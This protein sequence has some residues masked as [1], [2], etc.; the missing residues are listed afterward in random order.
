MGAGDVVR[1]V[2]L[3]GFLD[4]LPLDPR[5]PYL[6]APEQLAAQHAG[7]DGFYDACSGWGALAWASV[8]LQNYAHLTDRLKQLFYR[9]DYLQKAAA[10]T[11]M[12]ET[13]QERGSMI[14]FDNVTI[15]TPLGQLL[16]KDLTFRVDEGQSLLICGH[17]G[18]GKSSIIRCLCSLWPVVEGHI[19]R[20]GGAV[21]AE[22]DA[23]LHKQLYYLPQKPCNVLGSLSD[24]LTYPVKLAGGLPE[25][26]LRRWLRYVDLEYI[27]DRNIA[28]NSVSRV[29]RAEASDAQASR[30]IDWE[31]LL[32]LGEQ[33]ALSIARML[34]HHPRFAILDECTSGVGKVLEQRLFEI[35]QEVGISCI[36]IAHRPALKEFHAS[37]L[38]LTG[39]LEH[40][41][42]GWELSDI[43]HSRKLTPIR[44]PCVDT[45]EVHRR[46]ESFLEVDRRRRPSVHNVDSST[47]TDKTW[48][49]Q[50]SE[51][52][53]M[54]Q[55]SLVYKERAEQ[56]KAGASAADIVRKRWPSTAMRLWAIIRLGLCTRSE[57]QLA[58]KRVA[59]MVLGLCAQAK[60]YWWYNTCQVGMMRASM[61]GDLPLVFSAFLS[62]LV[63]GVSCGIA[64]QCVKFQAARLTKGIWESAMNRLQNRIMSGG[65]LSVVMRPSDKALATIENPAVRLSELLGVFESIS[66]QVKSVVPVVSALYSLP[67]L[68]R[69]VGALGPAFLA[70]LCVL[71]H[72]ARLLVPDWAAIKARSALLESRFQVLH[73]R[74]RSIAEPVAF[75]GGGA[76]ERR[77][78]EPHFDA[79]LNH[80]ERVSRRQT[81]HDIT[82]SIF[83]DHRNIPISL[84]AFVAATFAS[85]NRVATSIVGTSADTLLS[86][87]LFDRGVVQPALSGVVSL[88]D[89]SDAIGDIDGQCLR[90]LELVVTLESV[91]DP[92]SG[93]PVPGDGKISIS[94]LDLVTQRGSCLAQRLAFEVEVG[95]PIVVT[96]PN[97]SGKSLL[98]SVLL[99]LWPVAGVDARV[100]IAGASGPRPPLQIM[101]A[102]P[103]R[104]Y[105]SSGSLAAQLA[106]P[107]VLRLPSETPFGLLVSGFSNGTTCEMLQKHFEALG[108]LSRCEMLAQKDCTAVVH[109]TEQETMIKASA[110]P[111]DR[112]VDGMLLECEFVARE[113]LGDGPTPVDE[114]PNF[115]RMRLCLAATGLEHI[116]KR[117]R[118]G[119]FAE[120]VWEDTLSGGEQQRLCLARVLYNGPTFGLLD[121]C[122]SMVAADAEQDL[123]RR[124]FQEWGIT[125]ITLTQRSF[126]P[127]LYRRELSLGVPNAEGWEFSAAG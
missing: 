92:L 1:R 36:T 79:V 103:Q 77:I 93:E 32:S 19:A 24:Q 88:V 119:W 16:L 51:R 17:N 76:A 22:Q 98:C 30:D 64:D 78:V 18:A 11:E 3:E 4:Q 117:E 56:S 120:W 54:E 60:L 123:Y 121:E 69:G 99:G 66:A 71:S 65:V 108:C 80:S 106:Y 7:M 15:K 110:K 61:L 27:M 20:P 2:Q 21:H 81:L 95:V 87:L 29:N 115:R 53:L 126:M 12:R 68:C 33:Q 14:S 96:G 127:D 122:T 104:V 75:S 50:V 85:Y 91:D 52:T 8:E 116:L 102:A 107:I 44:P 25:E 9:L 114:V 101:K 49:R 83:T 74:L 35:C 113:H 86:T 109:F 34:Y 112:V 39:N 94:G 41:G 70:V 38:Q 57:Q 100:A 40:D 62:T 5:T 23:E 125:P 84:Q 13:F 90:C 26:E 89:S 10:P 42:N 63:T 37:L 45:S 82:K 43:Q 58:V 124:L 118:E 6:W 46:I 73:T 28:V 47:V 59:L 111:Y 48:K 31:V 105:L 72:G 97:A 67:T 55:R